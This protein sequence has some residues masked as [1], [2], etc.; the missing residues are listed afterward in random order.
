MAITP[1]F[2]KSWS[3]SGCKELAP[4]LTQILLLAAETRLVKEKNKINLQLPYVNAFSPQ[5]LCYDNINL[6]T[7]IFVEWGT[8]GSAKVTSWTFGILYKVCNGNPEHMKLAPILE[9][10]WK[11]KGLDFNND[12]QPRLPQLVPFHSQ[13]QICVINVLTTY[14][15]DFHIYAKNPNLQHKPQRKMP[16]GYKSEQFHCVSLWLEKP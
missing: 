2:I 14:C 6:S 16:E 3:V 1:K 7:S 8:S 9:C 10:F 15:V 11:V 4:T 12:I 5:L 13:L